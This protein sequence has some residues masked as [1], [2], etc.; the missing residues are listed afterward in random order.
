MVPDTDATPLVA[1]VTKPEISTAWRSFR[2]SLLRTSQKI[3]GRK[4]LS[5][6][7][8]RCACYLLPGLIAGMLARSGGSLSGSKFSTFI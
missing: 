5:R 4:A 2:K 8:Q 1:I 3:S 6:R 7:A